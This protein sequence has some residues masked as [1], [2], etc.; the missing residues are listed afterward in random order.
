MCRRCRADFTVLAYAVDD[1]GDLYGLDFILE[2]ARRRPDIPFLL[3]AATP[4]D[5]L[6]ANV[7]ALDWVEDTREVM[8]QST[9]YIRP[10][11]HDG[12]SNL[13][14]E[15][16][17]F[18]RHVMWT[19]PFPGVDVIDSVEAAQVRIDELHRQHVEGKLHSEPRG[20]GGR[21]RDVRA[22]VGA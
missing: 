2:L 21:A 3:L 7:T 5:A 9:L 11:S 17:A 6:P 18:G 10:T 1:R 15:A 14:L 22:L 20:Q 8:S 12:L 4:N 16:L 19:H 13:V